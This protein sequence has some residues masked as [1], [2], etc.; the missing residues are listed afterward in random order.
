RNARRRESALTQAGATARTV[1]PGSPT[2]IVI[3]PVVALN[4]LLSAWQQ[5]APMTVSTDAEP[6][7][8][9]G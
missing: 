2:L 9:K 6:A 5:T 4:P 1:T 7:R 8:A 3:G